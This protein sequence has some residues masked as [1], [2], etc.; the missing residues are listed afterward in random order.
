[1]TSLAQQVA[2]EDD[3]DDDDDTGCHSAGVAV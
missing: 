3:D 2:D 1:M